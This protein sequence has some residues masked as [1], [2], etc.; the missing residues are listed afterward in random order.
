[1]TTF[2]LV[3]GA[4]H[5]G[6]CW[7][8]VAQRLRAAGH[9]VYTPTLTGLCD[10]AHLATPETGVSTHIDDVVNLIRYEELEG[11]VLAGHSYGGF[12][13]T[14]VAERI[15]ERLGALVYVDAF[16]PADAA[17]RFAIDAGRLAD[18]QA[19]AKG[20]DG[21]RVPPPPATRWGID[22][23]ADRAWVDRLCTPHPL[24]CFE[25]VQTLTGAWRTV[26]RRSYILAG[27]YA[28]SP[29]QGF[30]AERKNDPSWR[31]RSLPAGH[32]MMVTVPGELAAVLIEA[33]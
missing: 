18:V 12:V 33:A 3:H 25:E 23:P 4:W 9:E 24:R 8:R 27:A 30:Y 28:G 14:G 32:D 17:T 1:M 13:I 16:V 21:W 10:R 31:L 2:V 19:A 6:W 7:R 11:V 22:D 29:F 20:N 5:G 26:A 15:A